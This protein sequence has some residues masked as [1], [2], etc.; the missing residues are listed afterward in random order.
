[1]VTR[2]SIQLLLIDTESICHA[3]TPKDIKSDLFVL[4][5]QE[6]ILKHFHSGVVNLDAKANEVNTIS[7]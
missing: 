3:F 7:T 4:V 2:N 6:N 1:M 5:I